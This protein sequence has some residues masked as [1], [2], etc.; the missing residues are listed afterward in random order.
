M[1]E[2]RRRVLLVDDNLEMA[3][4]LADGLGE[5]GFDA[6]AIESGR[7]AERRLASERFDAVVTDLRMP[8]VDGLRASRDLAEARSRP[9]GDRDDGLQRDRQRGRVDPAGRLPLP[10]EAVQA[11]RAGALPRARARRPRDPRDEAAALRQVAARA[12]LDLEHHRPQR[13]DARRARSDPAGRRRGRAGARARRDR[14]RQGAGRARAARRQRACERGPSSRSTAPRFPSRCSRASCSATIKGAFTGA[15]ADAPG[16]LRGG[17]RRHAVPRRDRRD[18]ARAAGEAAARARE[19]RGAP[20]RRQQGPRGR[21][22]HRRRHASRSRAQRV[23]RGPFRED[24]CTASTSSQLDGA[25][26]ARAARRTSRELAEH[27]LR[28]ARARNPAAPIADISARG[29]GAARALRLAR[30]RARAGTRGREARPVRVGR[31]RARR[32]RPGS[33]S[34]RRGPRQ[35]VAFQ[36]EIIALR[37]LDRRYTAWAVG[38]T[39]GHRGKAAEKLGIDPKTLRKLLDGAREDGE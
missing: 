37:E 4:T 35:S 11:G 30:Q 12:L 32:G 24:L 23:A 2:V 25:A 17:P 8:D 15:A 28:G 7:E 10:D 5:R 33:A 36:G 3:R 22:A 39:G 21:R 14:H 6:V 20:G 27:F 9:A 13:G 38:Q 26:A 19:R 16:L 18:A 34:E 1:T 29:A 31:G